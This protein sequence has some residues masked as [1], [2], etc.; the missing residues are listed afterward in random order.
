[1]T[2]HMTPVRLRLAALTLVPFALALLLSLTTFL[3]FHNELPDRLASR[4][5]TAGKP[6][7]YLGSTAAAVGST[8]LI[9][10]LAAVWAFTVHKGKLSARGVRGMLAGG[11]GISGLLGYLMPVNTL[12]NR[13]ATDGSDVRMP[14]WHLVAAAGVALVAAAVGLLLARTVPAEATAPAR[15]HET[16]RIDLAR[17]EVASWSHRLGSGMPLLAAAATLAGSVACGFAE[18]WYAA[19]ALLV[20][21]LLVLGFASAHVMVDRRGLTVAPSLLPWPAVRIPLKEVREVHSREINPV[22]DYGGWG[23]RV[24]SNRT[25][26]IL[27]SGEAIVVRRGN[28]R[29]FAVTVADSATGAALL[30]TL[31]DRRESR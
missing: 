17:G 12:A 9:A 18:Q 15:N 1:M 26:L 25:G 20:L 6:T 19:G 28:G 11:W 30:A 13:G 10:L 27:R 14:M 31:I 29:E 7:S 22:A 23:Y 24:R 16:G 8:L 3:I 2:L 5:D 4:F 21:G